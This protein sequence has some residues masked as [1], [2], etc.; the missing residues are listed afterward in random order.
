[1]ILEHYINYRRQ[2]MGTQPDKVYFSLI[3]ELSIVVRGFFHTIIQLLQLILFFLRHQC[4]LLYSHTWLEQ[5]ARERSMQGVVG[6][7]VVWKLWEETDREMAHIASNHTKVAKL[8]NAYSRQGRWTIC[9]SSVNQRKRNLTWG[10][11]EQT[12]VLSALFIG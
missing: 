10:E 12:A 7:E 3:S 8:S 2:T 4:P 9:F 5:E 11:R 1:M 6:K